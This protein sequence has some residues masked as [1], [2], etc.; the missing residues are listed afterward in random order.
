[1]NINYKPKHPC[2]NMLKQT[3]SEITL[4]RKVPLHN[5]QPES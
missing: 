3:K 5:H 1:M 2:T 4:T